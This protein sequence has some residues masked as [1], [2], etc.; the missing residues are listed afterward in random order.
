MEEAVPKKIPGP[1]PHHS[2][3]KTGFLE[4]LGTK[5]KVLP[6]PSSSTILSRKELGSVFQR[7]RGTEI[8]GFPVTQALVEI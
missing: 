1:P 6:K 4:L 8:G 7:E 5:N 2:P 3:D